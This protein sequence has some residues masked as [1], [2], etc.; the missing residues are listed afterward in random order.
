MLFIERTEHFLLV[1]NLT[2]IYIYLSLP[3]A[4]SINQT[5]YIPNR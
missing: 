2:S 1:S 4:T 5:F 3:I